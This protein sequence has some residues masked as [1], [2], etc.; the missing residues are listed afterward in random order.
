MSTG[1][2]GTLALYK[3]STFTGPLVIDTGVMVDLAYTGNQNIPSLTIGGVAQAPGV[4][5]SSALNPS[6]VFTGPGTVTLVPP[7]PVL[8]PGGFTGAPGS[9]T[10]TWHTAAGWH[11]R[12]V[13]SATA[14]APLNTWTPVIIP[15]T[16]PGPNGWSAAVSTG[17]DM[18]LVDPSPST[19]QRFYRIEA[20]P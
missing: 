13:Y 16:Y 3:L 10:F 19:T 11:Y 17:A 6:G 12:V 15:V 7:P 4:Y 2:A 8:P 9:P 14:N 1:G 20:G 5:G 18:T